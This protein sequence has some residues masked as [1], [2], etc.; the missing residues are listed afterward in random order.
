MK[1]LDSPSSPAVDA[2]SQPLTLMLLLMAF[3][4]VFFWGYSFIS[5]KQ[6]LLIDLAPAQ[7][8][9]IRF[10]IA[11][12]V[13]AVLTRHEYRWL[14]LKT[15]MHFLLCGLMGGPLYFLTENYAL[16]YTL[17][18]NVGLLT[19]TT[20][21]TTAL[22]LCL[23]VRTERLHWP[24]VVGSL[25]ALAGVAA[26]MYNSGQEFQFSFLGDTLALL[27]SL[28]WAIYAI[29][30]R[31]LLQRYSA[32]VL[33]RKVFFW[34][35]VFTIPFACAEEFPMEALCLPQFYLHIGILSLCCSLQAFLL[36][37][38][39]VSKI[40]VIR[41][42]NF[43]Y[44]NPIV[45]LVCSVLILD[46]TLTLIGLIGCVLILAGVIFAEKMKR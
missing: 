31:G 3:T 6:L 5:T 11:Y 30:Q 24:L 39:L 46:E 44:I 21:L 8:Y 15:E 2:N 32:L 28:S 27:A 41:A 22:L 33:T 20:P 7:I 16:K 26:V 4:M 12:L 25:V 38:H 29:L 40:G 9:I 19:S 42:S 43:I 10:I 17:V 35:V 34:G 13:L 14:G 1:D 18:S 45:T 36:W 37:G 23:M